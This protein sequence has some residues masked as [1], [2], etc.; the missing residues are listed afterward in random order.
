MERADFKRTYAF[1]QALLKGP[2]HAHHLAGGFHLGAERIV[3]VRE[4]IEGEAG[5][6]G[7]DIVQGR[8]KGS[9]RVGQPN[10][11]QGHAHADLGGDPGDRIAAGFGGQR[12][13]AGDPGIYLDQI[14][15][16]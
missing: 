3:G 1:E 9:G 6:L 2:A 8:L 12:R 10:L 7:D 13:G 11:V 4:L 16:E 15:L 5:Q 14:I